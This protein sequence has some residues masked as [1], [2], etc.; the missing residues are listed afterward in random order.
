MEEKKED[1]ID[2]GA[3]IKRVW[4]K[5]KLFYKAWPIA[6]VVSALIIICVPRTYTASAKLAP[7]LSGGSSA[8]GSLSSL[9]SS[10]GLDIGDGLTEDAIS[11]LLYPDLMEDNGFIMSLLSIQVR[12]CDGGIDTTYYH[13]LDKCQKHAWWTYIGKALKRLMPKPKDIEVKGAGEEKKDPYILSKREDGIVDMVK[14]NITLSVDKKTGVIT[15]VTQ[16]QD[17]LVSKT[18]AD[19]T[20]VRLQRFITEYRTNKA[21]VDLEYYKKMVAEA[22]EAYDKARHEYSTFSDSNNDMVLQTYRSRLTDLEN[23]M[24]LMF[25]AYN[26]MQTQLQASMAKVQE[27]TPAFTQLKGA[28]LPLKA[29]GPK[30]MLFV[31]GMLILTTIGCVVFVLRR[32]IKDYLSP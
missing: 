8:A 6:F 24:Q 9:A 4:H 13:Y 16:A 12:T 28:Q 21:R 7:E 31:L 10:F 17:P 2:I 32:E 29:S 3:I 25:N 30:R 15:I 22:K 18:L 11:P 27:R 14:K 20:S 26:T 19:S 23:E 5:R 1:I